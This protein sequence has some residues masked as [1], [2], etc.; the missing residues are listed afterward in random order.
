MSL[1]IYKKY[2]DKPLFRINETPDFNKQADQDAFLQGMKT[3]Q[4]LIQ[5]ELNVNQS[6]QTLLGKRIEMMKGFINDLPASDPQYHMLLIQIQMDQ[7][8]LNELKVR[9]SLLNKSL[10][11]S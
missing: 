4:D 5:K 9:E 7:I 2:M 6:E 8:E 10:Y 11:L 3:S 1:T